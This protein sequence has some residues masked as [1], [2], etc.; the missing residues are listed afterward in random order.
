[1][2]TE[3]NIARVARECAIDLAEDGVVYAEVRFAPE[4]HTQKGLKHVE[5]IDAVLRGFR[6]GEAIAVAAG[7]PIRMEGLLVA[8]RHAAKSSA[9]AELVVAY[10]DRGIVGFDIAGA[11]AGF[12]LCA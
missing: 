4:L 7:N 12:P 3:E 1:M 6:E 5:V 2:Q 8:M 9:I 10:R 11:E